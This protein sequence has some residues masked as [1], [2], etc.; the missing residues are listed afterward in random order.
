LRPTK[1]NT[2]ATD[3]RAMHRAARIAPL[4]AIPAGPER[5]LVYSFGCGGVPNVP[6]R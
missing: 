2:A 3:I 1:A 5:D 6:S 4:V